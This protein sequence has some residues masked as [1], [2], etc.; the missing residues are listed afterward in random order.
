MYDDA[1][2]DSGSGNPYGGERHPRN[3]PEEEANAE[4]RIAEGSGGLAG[5][6]A[7]AGIGSFVGPIGTIIG[8]LGGAVGGWWAGRAAS[9]SSDEYTP[10]D[11]DFYQSHYQAARP[12]GSSST[13]D[14][15]RPAYQL[16][17]LAGMNPDYRSRTFEE[18]EPDLSSAY[19]SSGQNNWHAVRIYARDAYS[20]SRDRGSSQASNL[21]TS[22]QTR[23]LSGGTKGFADRVADAADDVKD[24]FDNNPAS[25][26]GRDATDRPGR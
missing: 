25:R 15:H 16:G 17:H 19:S 24:R 26:P 14:E 10:D 20:R 3:S 9:K 13:Y 23:D 5:M 1:S 21:R 11:D 2:R 7:G 12:S 8:A 4:E 6:A 22:E 18:V